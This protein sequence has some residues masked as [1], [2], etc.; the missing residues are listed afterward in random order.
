MVRGIKLKQI[1]FDMSERL[2]RLNDEIMIIK[3][4]LKWIKRLIF[5]ILAVLLGLGL[6]VFL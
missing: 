5:I 3:N 4:D 2:D 1:L 6:G